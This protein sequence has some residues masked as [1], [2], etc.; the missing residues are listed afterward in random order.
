MRYSFP[1]G[2]QQTVDSPEDEHFDLIV[3]RA[4]RRFIL[5]DALG[6]LDASLPGDALA[7]RKVGVVFGYPDC[8]RK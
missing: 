4:A 7:Y 2:G 1:A 3:Q 5:H 8:G 6:S